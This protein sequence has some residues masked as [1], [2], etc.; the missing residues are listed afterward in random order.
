MSIGMQPA[1]PPP[2]GPRFKPATPVPSF[3]K[4]VGQRAVC[5]RSRDPVGSMI[6]ESQKRVSR[7]R[8]VGRNDRKS[9]PRKS[10]KQTPSFEELLKHA[11]ENK[12][13]IQKE[14][15][16]QSMRQL[17]EMAAD[18]AEYTASTQDQA[19]DLLSDAE[20][21]EQKL[22]MVLQR[23]LREVLATSDSDTQ[24]R[25]AEKLWKWFLQK[26]EQFKQ[27][28]EQEQ[29]RREVAQGGKKRRTFDGELRLNKPELFKRLPSKTWAS[30][31]GEFRPDT[32]LDELRLQGFV[33]DDVELATPSKEATPR[34]KRVQKEEYPTSPCKAGPGRHTG[35][36]VLG[37]RSD[38]KAVRQNRDLWL[39]QYPQRSIHTNEITPGKRLVMTRNEREPDL[40]MGS[41]VGSGNGPAVHYINTTNRRPHSSLGFASTQGRRSDSKDFKAIKARHEGAAD[42]LKFAFQYYDVSDDSKEQSMHN[43]YLRTVEGKLHNTLRRGMLD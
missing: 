28:N 12:T 19:Q 4:A 6:N 33:V 24:L 27:L 14:K 32:P 10:G 38:A 36:G 30:K 3:K 22:Y 41:G 9:V 16:R 2:E 34:E 39:S 1:G 7:V 37:M 26:R 18:I 21:W 23:M 13:G 5:R 29:A 11:L 8:M 43:M 42:R 20:L 15:H 35:E 40:S 25:L 31:F 17:S